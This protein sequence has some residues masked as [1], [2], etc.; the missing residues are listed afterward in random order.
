MQTRIDRTKGNEVII[1]GEISAEDFEK[2]REA[3]S[4]HLGRDL[5][6]PGFRKGHAP[7]HIVA[8][9]IGGGRVLE[10]M[11]NRALAEHLPKLF[12]EHKIDAIGR[13]QIT[14]TKLAPGNPLGFK[15][16]TAVLPE[17]TLPDYRALART[18]NEKPLEPV[19]VSEKEVEDAI[20]DI[21]RRA[22]AAEPSKVVE[23]EDKP[24]PELTDETVKVLGNFTNVADFKKKL[25]DD[26]QTFKKR[27]VRERRRIV[28]IEDI[29]KGTTVSLPTLLVEAELDKMLARFKDDVA[30]V[31]AKWD[32][33]LTQIKKTEEDL[34]REWHPDAEKNATIQLVLNEIAKKENIR[35]D[36]KAVELEVT[37]LKSHYPD[38]DP[39][40]LAVYVRTLLTNE[41]V[42]EFLENQK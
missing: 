18:Q 15:L 17:I 2:H 20:R 7:A 1:E 37:H 42:F 22:R 36:D 23:P 10:E 6:V 29:V 14:V 25:T 9:H 5:E 40:G 39:Q 13:P 16:T 31:G 32:D 8:G 38:A 30:R 4:S 35:P 41:K 11:A 28:T 19:V 33:Y 21:R 26:I 27:Q 12:I 34:R 24:L 3:A